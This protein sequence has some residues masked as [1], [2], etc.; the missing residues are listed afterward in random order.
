MTPIAPHITA[1]L[2]ER[3]PLE[4]RASLHTCETYSHA[5]RLLFEFA[6]ARLKT[7]PSQLQLEQIDVQLILAFLDHLER[8]RG[9]GAASRNSRLAAI[10][11]FMR[12]V[13]YRVPSALDQ[14]RQILA[15][16][17]KKTETKL[18]RHLTM[19]EMQAILDAPDPRTRLGIR[20]Q[21]MLHTCFVGG[22]RVSEL[23]GLRIENVSFDPRPCLRV[24]GKGRRERL[25]PLWKQSGALL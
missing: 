12:F 14:V 10:K 23:V 15:I 19:A 25:L 16:P 6:A 11:S 3:L 1:F 7:T 18:V 13:E 2:R 9:N 24:V 8:D 17:Q 21:A 5:F 20:D 4:R 22:L